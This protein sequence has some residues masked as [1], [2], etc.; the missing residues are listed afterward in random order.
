MKSFFLLALL[1]LVFSAWTPTGEPMLPLGAQLPL[2]N[3]RM[4]GIDGKDYQLAKAAGER[5]LLVVFTCNTCPFVLAW[6]ETFPQV[7]EW[8]AQA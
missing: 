4:T 1:P 6:E 2:A 7:E 8:A 5:G 3:Y